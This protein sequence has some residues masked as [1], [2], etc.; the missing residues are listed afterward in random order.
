VIRFT[1]A[2]SVNAS[3]NLSVCM[4]DVKLVVTGT[5]AVPVNFRAPPLCR[6]WEAT[7]PTSSSTFFSVQSCLVI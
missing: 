1:V 5:G 3:W 7:L 4:G 6:R 2:L